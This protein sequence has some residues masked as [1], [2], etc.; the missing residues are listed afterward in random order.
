MIPKG[1]LAEFK[2]RI[3]SYL[4]KQTWIN[5]IKEFINCDKNKFITF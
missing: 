5:E 2:T 3:V 1:P 4:E